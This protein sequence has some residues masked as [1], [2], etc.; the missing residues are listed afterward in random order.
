M[1]E[2]RTISGFMR[3]SMPSS[4][5]R[6]A[7][8]SVVSSFRKVRAGLRSAAVTVCQPYMMTRAVG[9][10]AQGVAAGA[11][12]AF[13]PLDLLAGRAWFGRSDAGNG[14]PWRL[15][16]TETLVRRNSLH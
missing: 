14:V 3:G 10:A 9:L 7:A 6:R 8:F 13:A 5:S 12:E 2:G 4:A 16:L 11:F 15:A 1:A